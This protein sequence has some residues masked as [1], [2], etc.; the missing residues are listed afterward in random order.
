MF[1][2]GRAAY[3]G[4]PRER[5]ETGSAVAL[6]SV[7]EGSGYLTVT[8]DGRVMAFG[9]ATSLGDDLDV[10]DTG[11][12]AIVDLAAVPSGDGA[13]ALDG[14]GGV[15]SVAGAGFYGS[16][17]GLDLGISVQAVSITPTSR[18]RGYWVLD[19]VGGVF[20]FGDAEYHG[21][22]P[23]SG[24]ASAAPAVAL[25][26]APNDEG[27]TI[28]GEDGSTRSFGRV[29]VSGAAEEAAVPALHPIVAATKT[30]D[31]LL[32][33]DALGIIYPVGG[34]PFHGSPVTLP[35]AAPIVDIAWSGG[36]ARR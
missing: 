36:H 6:T 26:A 25:V 31:G 11:T 7:G 19:R 1:C 2:F 9:D 8:A 20:C 17:P 23:E 32:L 35:L 34:A 30:P 24:E 5:G 13:W 4:S 27:Y 3:L 28:V 10:A 33:V 15:F 16:V 29:V 14:L 21:S 12:A 18:D 22:V